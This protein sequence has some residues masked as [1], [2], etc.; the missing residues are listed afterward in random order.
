MASE[1]SVDVLVRAFE[2]SGMGTGDVAR[3]LGLKRRYVKNG[4]TY[5]VTDHTPVRRLLGRH[6]DGKGRLQKGTSYH[7][8]LRFIVACGHDPVDYGL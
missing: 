2:D 5:W 7:K 3:A 8:A 1:V 6:P 4:R